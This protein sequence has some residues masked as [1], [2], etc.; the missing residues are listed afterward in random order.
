MG[1]AELWE[2][3]LCL[4]GTSL[5]IFQ[6]LVPRWQESS[7]SLEEC[8]TSPRCYRNTG[9]LGVMAPEPP[10]SGSSSDF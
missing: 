6:L 7:T 2:G 9:H 1:P 3:G 8:N 10:H 4:L 5:E